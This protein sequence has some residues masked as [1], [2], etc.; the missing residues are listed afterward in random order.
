MV[1]LAPFIAEYLAN[2]LSPNERVTKCRNCDEIGHESRD[3]PK[4]KDW[5]RVQCNNCK[6]Y[7]T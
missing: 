2:G 6:E 1:C 7:G 4:P 3:C 5:S